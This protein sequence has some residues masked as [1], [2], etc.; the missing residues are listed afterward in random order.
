MFKK[1]PKPLVFKCDKEQ[2][3]K[4][5]EELK[6]QRQNNRVEFMIYQIEE[7][8][9]YRRMKNKIMSYIHNKIFFI[10]LKLKY[11]KH[12]LKRYIKHLKR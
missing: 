9:K 6:K 7:T 3:E 11:Y 12:K 5:W 10:K 1:K 4:A 8:S 2:V